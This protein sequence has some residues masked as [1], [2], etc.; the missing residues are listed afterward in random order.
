MTSAIGP[1]DVKPA[2]AV[3]V[4]P[5]ARA[6][7]TTRVVKAGMAFDLDEGVGPKAEPAPSH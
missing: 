2:E 5:T 7:R 4:D 1:G 6:E 3:G